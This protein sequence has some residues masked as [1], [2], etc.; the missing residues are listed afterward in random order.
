M[1]KTIIKLMNFF[2]FFYVT[3]NRTG[4]RLYI[5]TD[6]PIFINILP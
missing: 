2:Y 3:L 5:R 6:K 4:K 1:G